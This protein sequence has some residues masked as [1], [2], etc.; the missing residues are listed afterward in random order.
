M[1]VNTFNL[2]IYFIKKNIKNSFMM[3]IVNII[4][5]HLFYFLRYTHL[6]LSYF[7]LHSKVVKKISVIVIIFIIKK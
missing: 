4:C 5:L 7:D 1:N 3:N 6:P 2:S